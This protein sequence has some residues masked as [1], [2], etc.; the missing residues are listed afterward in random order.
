MIARLYGVSA[1]VPAFAAAPLSLVE[2][3]PLIAASQV[4]WLG[5]H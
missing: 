3:V 5:P 1:P 2:L 4:M